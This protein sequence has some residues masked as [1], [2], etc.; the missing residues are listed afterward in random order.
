MTDSPVSG[1]YEVVMGRN[2]AY[3]DEHGRY[4]LF[5]HLFDLPAQR[6]LTA[7]HKDELARIDFNQLPLDDAI[8]TVHGAGSRVL[9]VF[10]DPDCRSCKQLEPEIAKVNDVTIYTFL[11]PLTQLH[12]DARTK[13][14]SVWC[15]ADR[16]K[17]WAAL[18]LRNQ[19]PAAANCDHPV[20]RNVALG[21]RYQI[22]GTPTLIAADGR[23]MPGAASAAHIEDWLGKTPTHV[24][25]HKR[26]RDAHNE[27]RCAR[28]SDCRE[29]VA[30]VGMR[31]QARGLGRKPELRMQGAGRRALHI[32]CRR[33][34]QFAAKQPP[35]PAHGQA[36]NRRREQCR[37]RRAHPGRLRSGARQRVDTLGATGF[38][39]VAKRVGGQRRRFAGPVLSLPRR[40]FRPLVDRTST[41]FS[42]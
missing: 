15:G 39:R 25:R 19:T 4:F 3:T 20:D 13:A 41:R 7:E 8:K 11:M 18:M 37:H 2:I 24:R 28:S 12:P 23:V 5:G 30:G 27:K 32:G 9:A 10:S 38:A 1:I 22:S 35:Q 36:R 33:L 26:V 14:I 16:V 6:D 34:R 40:R 42:P 21:E 29:R 17:A 31:F